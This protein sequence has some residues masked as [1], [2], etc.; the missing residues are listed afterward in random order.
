HRYGA[1]LYVA[2]NIL[3]KDQEID[4]AVER[5]TGWIKAGIDGLI[6][7]DLGLYHILRK[8]FPTLEIHSSTQM[9]IH[10]PSGVKLLE[11]DGFDRIVLAP[12]GTPG[13]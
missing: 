1:K 6:V 13:G 8:T 10:G 3:I 4:R 2:A 11:E 9:F 7:Q 12:G 5:I